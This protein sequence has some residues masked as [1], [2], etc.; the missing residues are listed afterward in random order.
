MIRL[1]SHKKINRSWAKTHSYSYKPLAISDDAKKQLSWGGVVSIAPLTPQFND[2]GSLT[3]NA[4]KSFRS[5]RIAIVTATIPADVIKAIKNKNVVQ[6]VGELRD[7]TR[8]YADINHLGYDP[9]CFSCTRRNGRRFQG[10]K[11]FF[12]DKRNR[13]NNSPS[14]I[15]TKFYNIIARMCDRQDL[16]VDHTAKYKGEKE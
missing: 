6:S 3:L 11:D 9:L 7:L 16:I 14:S 15:N 12:I 5:G 13:L 1:T 4:R 10:V 8:E 2:D